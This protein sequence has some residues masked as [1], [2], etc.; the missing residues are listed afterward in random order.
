MRMISSLSNPQVKQLRAL[1]QRKERAATGLFFVEGIRLVAEA[2]QLGAPIE[3]L[4]VAPELLKSEF[5]QELVARRR[6]SGLAVLEVTP[7]VF[8]SLSGKEGPQGLG[9]VVRQRWE[10]LWDDDRE[11]L[12]SDVPL[13]GGGQPSSSADR[14]PPVLWVALDSVADP[15]N[16]GTILRTCDAVGATGVILLGEATDPHDPAAVRASMGA[17]F[18]QRLVRA[19]AA[20]LGPW[21]H[22]RGLRIVGTSDAAATD[23]QA[24]DYRVPLALLMGSERQGLSGELLALCD[25]VV[26]IPMAGRS[27]S[28]NLA[29]ATGVM[30][31]EIFNQRRHRAQGG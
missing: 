30:L 28:L 18:A 8:A 4:V 14:P 21:A 3:A 29:V 31:Y 20:E 27:D 7:D 15:G 22:R 26:R 19:D 16:L 11:P 13:A 17:I 24:V 9:A 23:Y 6:A 5:G 25:A 12:R 2:V 1:R 10:R